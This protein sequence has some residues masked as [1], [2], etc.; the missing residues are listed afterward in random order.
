[1]SYLEMSDVKHGFFD[2]DATEKKGLELTDQYNDG[3]PYPHIVIDDFLPLEILESC[4]KRFPKALDKE[5]MTFNRPQE[6]L[7][8]SFNPDHLEGALRGFFYSFNS[9]PFI[10]FL[11]NLTG[12]KGLIPDP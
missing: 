3:N 8:S 12:I 4:L 2:V 10:R 5:G 6:R 11:E 7:K 1:M 9:K